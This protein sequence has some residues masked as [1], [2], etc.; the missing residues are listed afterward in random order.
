[1]ANY[2]HKPGNGSIFKNQYKEKDGQP[3]YKGSVKL[4]D[5]T[6]KEVAGWIKQDKNGNQFLSLS[7][8]DPYKKD[9]PVAQPDTASGTDLPF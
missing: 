5:G 1:M 9:N 4:Q 8:S 6:D 3:D 2:E 7:I